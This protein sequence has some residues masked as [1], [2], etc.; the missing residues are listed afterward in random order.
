M[1]DYVK[2]L[3]DLFS[4]FDILKEKIADIYEQS[5]KQD[6]FQNCT[7]LGHCDRHISTMKELALNLIVD[8]EEK[9]S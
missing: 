8:I 1:N 3:K 2:E 6:M 9:E 5:L 7:T 4:D